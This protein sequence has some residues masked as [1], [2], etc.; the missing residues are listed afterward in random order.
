MQKKLSENSVLARDGGCW[1][2]SIEGE[3]HSSGAASNGK[4]S[5]DYITGMNGTKRVGGKVRSRLDLSRE[6]GRE[7]GQGNPSWARMSG[8]GAGKTLLF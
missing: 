5:G 4:K 7:L 8:N 6:V 3:Q 1:G 2:G